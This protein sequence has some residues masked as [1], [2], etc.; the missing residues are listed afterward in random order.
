MPINFE[1]TITGLCVIVPKSKNDYPTEPDSV[2]VLCVGAH[3]HRPVLSFWPEDM[4][5]I[6][7]PTYLE[8]DLCVDPKGR[9]IASLSVSSR[10]ISFI[11]GSNTN[12]FSLTWGA[13]TSVE[14]PEKRWMNWI[15]PANFLGVSGVRIG[16]AGE[17]PIG[18][19]ARVTLPPGTIE[20]EEIIVDSQGT[21]ALQWNF[22][23][24]NKQRALANKVV[25][26]VPNVSY[27]KVLVDGTER[28][29]S[30]ATNRPFFMSLSNDLISVP[31]DY[32][33]GVEELHHLKHLTNLAEP[34][35]T[36]IPPKVVTDLGRTGKPICNQ[37][38]FVDKS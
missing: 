33:L 14:P 2:D 22:S 37:V 15:A 13:E 26:K 20:A 24:V 35:A 36:V 32:N 18:A 31:Y 7:K 17:V 4:E 1:L 27:V 8:P 38:L 34:P 5:P 16:K 29:I 10:F 6:S 21:A 11:C 23:A 19:G 30:T 3:H 9:R 12:K 25:C 28:L